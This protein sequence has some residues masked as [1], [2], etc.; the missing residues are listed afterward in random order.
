MGWEL[1]GERG[2][3][4]E[5]EDGAGTRKWGRVGRA[6]LAGA[7]SFPRR[8]K[9]TWRGVSSFWL[10]ASGFFGRRFAHSSSKIALCPSIL[11]L[12]FRHHWSF[13]AYL[14][15]SIHPSI[16]FPLTFCISNFRFL[17][18]PIVQMSRLSWM[19]MAKCVNHERYSI[20]PLLARD[21]LSKKAG[22]DR[23]RGGVVREGA[24]RPRRV[25]IKGRGSC[26]VVLVLGLVIVHRGNGRKWRK[27]GRV[28]ESGEGCSEVVE[29]CNKLVW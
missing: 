22:R 26:V 8:H 16:R 13:S 7:N 18:P 14:N 12:F 25:E 28:G 19:A 24:F 2:Q 20:P 27:W 10:L 9:H 17:P 23:A 3:G 29:S 15:Q 6:V 5:R 11:L 1:N 21:R 4:Y